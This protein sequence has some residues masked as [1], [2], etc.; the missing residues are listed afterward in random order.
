MR[1][2]RQ[3][4][5]A[6]RL[7]LATVDDAEFVVCN[8]ID[9]GLDE[10]IPPGQAL[11][12]PCYG[13]RCTSNLWVN[14]AHLED[15][16]LPTCFPCVPRGSI[17]NELEVDVAETHLATALYPGVNQMR[18]VAT[19]QLLVWAESLV[20]TTM[21]PTEVLGRGGSFDHVHFEVNH[22]KVLLRAVCVHKRAHHWRWDIAVT[23]Q[24][25]RR[26]LATF[27]LQFRAVNGAAF[28][29]HHVEPRQLQLR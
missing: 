14:R 23:N 20:M 3:R 26:D 15:G 12:Q 13:G 16:I 5:A 25:D 17:R 29:R 24:Q 2:L 1:W 21:L 18:V 4:K 9:E 6:P 27:H 28:R 22:T 8:T 10:T 7:S 19:A 11:M